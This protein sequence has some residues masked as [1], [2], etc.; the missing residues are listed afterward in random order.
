MQE[1]E[2]ARYIGDVLDY[3]R[4]LNKIDAYVMAFLKPGLILPVFSVLAT[5]S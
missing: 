3:Y 4:V 5:F 1:W 2:H